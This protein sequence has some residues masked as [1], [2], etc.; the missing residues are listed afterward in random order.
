MPSGYSAS[1]ADEIEVETLRKLLPEQY[2]ALEDALA[3][4][5]YSLA[6]FAQ[7]KQMEENLFKDEAKQHSLDVAFDGLNKE[8]NNRF[9]GLS[10]ELCYHDQDNLGDC[11]DD[12]NGAFFH[13]EGLYVLSPGAEKLGKGNWERKHYVQ[14]G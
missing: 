9:D 4:G 13:V 11:Y 2:K 5:G 8:F 7:A 12:V 14:Y 3:A 10:L 1:Y 6:D